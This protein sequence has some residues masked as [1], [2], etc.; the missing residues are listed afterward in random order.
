MDGTGLEPPSHH[1]RG[2]ILGG[3]MVEIS[4]NKVVIPD[5]PERPAAKRARVEIPIDY[6]L[7]EPMR[8]TQSQVFLL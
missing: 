7:H 3:K 6:S 1:P 4:T 8:V 2:L 5:S